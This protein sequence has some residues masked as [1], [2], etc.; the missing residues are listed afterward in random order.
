MGLDPQVAA[1]SG[2][3]GEPAGLPECLETLLHEQPL[4][5]RQRSLALDFF[6]VQEFPERKREHL[7]RERPPAHL[8]GDLP[9]QHPG[10]R[11]CQVDLAFFRAHHALDKG[12]PTWG[13]LDLVE[14]AVDRLGVFL[15][16][17]DGVIG[18]GDQAE[19]VLPQVVKPVV[20]KVQVEDVLPGDPA[21]QQ[22]LDNLEQVRRLAA[23]AHPDAD[24]GLAGYRLDAQTPGHTGLQPGLLEIQDDGFDR[25][26]HRATPDHYSFRLT[27]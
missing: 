26:N 24:S 1:K 16:R 21:G 4:F 27:N 8:R 25:L 7:P 15:L 22:P 5:R 23:P 9:G 3:L 6:A 2:G 19:I 11:T 14:K 12:L 13:G 20:E 10:R 17:V 18:L